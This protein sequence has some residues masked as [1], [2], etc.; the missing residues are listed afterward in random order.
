VR[1]T[2]L[3]VTAPITEDPMPSSF[4]L[5]WILSELA[6]RPV[7]RSDPSQYELQRIDA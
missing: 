7:M 1:S 3:S 6:H 4:F 5:Y 2:F